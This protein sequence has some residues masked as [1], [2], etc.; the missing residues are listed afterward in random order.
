MSNKKNHGFAYIDFIFGI[1]IISIALFP[2]LLMTSNATIQHKQTLLTSRGTTFCNSVMQQIRSARFD[3]LAGPWPN[4]STVLGHD[5]GDRDDIDDY[6][7]NADWS[8]ITGFSDFTVVI[9]VYYINPSLIP[10]S[11]IANAGVV[12]DY[13]RI[14]VI[15]SHQEL[16]SP[17]TLSSIMTPFG[18]F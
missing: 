6:T 12:T 3:D 2:A 8:L 13:K 18:Y 5:S 15:V 4:W 11:W 10:S 7:N 16:K 1:V 14:V 9:N 17:L